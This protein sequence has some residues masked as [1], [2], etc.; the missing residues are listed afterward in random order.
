M[1]KAR[2]PVV[3]DESILPANDLA[4][5]LGSGLEPTASLKQIAEMRLVSRRFFS[6][7]KVLACLFSQHYPAIIKDQFVVPVGKVVAVFDS[8]TRVGHADRF[9][10]F[11]RIRCPF[12]YPHSARSC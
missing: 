6:N 12:G 8:A 4:G 3:R 10:G 11:I 7:G 5:F 1:W 2:E 9:R